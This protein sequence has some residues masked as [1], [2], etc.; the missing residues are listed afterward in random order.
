MTGWREVGR[1]R[2]ARGTCS[3]L[4]NPRTPMRARRPRLVGSVSDA[5]RPTGTVARQLESSRSGSSNLRPA[6]KS[7]ISNFP[8]GNWRGASAPRT[9]RHARNTRH[10]R[11]RNNFFDEVARHFHSATGLCRV[12]LSQVELYAFP[13]D[14][15][16]RRRLIP[17]TQAATTTPLRNDLADA[18]GRCGPRFSRNPATVTWASV[19]TASPQGRWHQL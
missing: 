9:C 12:P 14:R 17:L 3:L 8:P 13:V 11:K 7:G 2:S 18:D 15:S 16:R 1:R 19:P 6:Q 10:R 4:G 5:S